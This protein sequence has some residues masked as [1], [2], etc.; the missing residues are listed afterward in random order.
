MEDPLR[1][2]LTLAAGVV[3]GMLSAAFGVGGAVVS[4]PAVR[5]LGA[6]ALD[7]VGT[8][9]P[10]ILP[11]AITGTL[12]YRREGLV[13]WNAVRWTGGAGAVS[14]V[15]GALIARH[16]PGNGHL[17]MVITAGFMAFT[18]IRVVATPRAA[19]PVEPSGV[20]GEPAHTPGRPMH[21]LV[22]GLLAG[23]LS[24]LLGVGGG[25]VMVPAFTG[26]LRW[27]IKEAVGTSLACVGILAI[28][29]SITHAALG[30]IDWSYAIPLAI[31]VV[32]GARLGAGLALRATDRSLRLAVAIALGTIAIAYAAAE[33]AAL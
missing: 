28:P 33:L 6:T 26:W 15:F 9:L 4:T 25:I 16:V 14:A 29:G 7:A 13:R 1:I 24:G 20:P 17:L 31:G 21:L 11:S 30:G 23:G 22:I 27:S 10:A 12:R 2:A 18:A 3:T 8:T 32:P 5:A 19:Q